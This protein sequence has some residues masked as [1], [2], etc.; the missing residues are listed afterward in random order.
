MR[1]ITKVRIIRAALP[2]AA[3]VCSALLGYDATRSMFAQTPPPT[4]ITMVANQNVYAPG[5]DVTVYIKN[6]SQ[7]SIFIPN[8]C[9]NEPL[10]VY[11]Q[12]HGAWVQ[13]HAAADSAK[14]AG[15]PRIYEIAAG[16]AV[17]VDYSDW[18]SLFSQSGTYRIVALLQSYD[19]GPT[20]SFTVAAR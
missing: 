9:P 13:I 19:S 3:I 12:E 20:V 1:Y 8:K 5:Q 2:V 10:A 4:N 11:R 14:C 6:A 17:A 18:P 15:A 16:R 7:K